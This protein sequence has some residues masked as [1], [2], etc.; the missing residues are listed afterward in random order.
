[1]K[2]LAMI[3]RANHFRGGHIAKD[4]SLGSNRCLLARNDGHRDDLN[5]YLRHCVLAPCEN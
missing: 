2:A 5:S 4:A 1:V 3:V